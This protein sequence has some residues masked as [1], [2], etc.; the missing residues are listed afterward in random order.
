M[1]KRKLDA[2]KKPG[3]SPKKSKQGPDSV[4]IKQQIGDTEKKLTKNEI[5]S[6]KRPTTTTD[7][8]GKKFKSFQKVS[9]GKKKS[10]NL[11][12]KPADWNEFKKK[13]KEVRLKRKQSKNLF[14]IIIKA[15]QIG[16]T[17]RKKTL[18]KK[19]KKEV[20]LKR[21]QSKNLFE[22]IIKAKQIG[23]TLRKKTLSGGKA[24]RDR[25]VN[26]LHK[27][28]GGQGNY[29][30]FVLTHDMARIVQYMLKFG[31]QNI[32]EDIA[33]EIIPSTVLMLQSKYGRYCIKRL[34][35]YGNAKTRSEAIKA[36]YGNAVKL[37]S[38]VVSAQIFEYIY[39]TWTQPIEKVH[40]IQEFF[41]DLYKQSK[42]DN[43]KHLQDVYKNSPSMKAAALG[44][45]KANLSRVLN[46]DLL[47]S[48]LIQSVLYQYITECNENDR[49]DLI[50]QLASH[51]VILCNS[52]D[53][54]RTVM[55]CIWHGTNKDRKV[56]MKA[57]KEHVVD[58]CKH[59]FGHTVLIAIFDGIDDTVLVNKMIISEILK[60][61][62]DIS[63]DEWGRKVILWLVV[64]AHTTHFHPTFTNELE[65]G[66]QKSSSKKTP[67]ARRK[68]ILEYSTNILLTSVATET[69]TWFSSGSISVVA[70]A[71]LKTGNG[72]VLTE[73]LGKVA[74]LIVEN[75]WRIKE[76]EEE[77]LAIEHAGLH[78]TL[79]KLVQNDK[80]AIENN[81]PT[82]SKALVNLLQEDVIKTW[83][84]MNRGCFLLI[85]ILE[86]GSE[87]IVNKLKESLMNHL[88]LIKK[89]KTAGSKIILKKLV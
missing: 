59:E 31:N 68:E 67:E 48:R 74:R 30:K 61:T 24:E 2:P 76:E 64:P 87:D 21:K 12:E 47:D 70:L 38:H 10:N 53:G 56:I 49:N 54:S 36:M 25:L 69:R 89:E 46:K 28:L 55:E 1:T 80:Q 23:E 16:E 45:V 32:R 26:E 9:N 8:Q 82:F 13:K 51:A 73:A 19:K 50:S 14:E 77:I 4:N 88:K 71:I 18:S 85:A 84:K 75:D 43:V 34:F 83:I 60:H 72:E 86:N 37:T 22:I 81:K 65:C 11:M 35:K 78:M 41:G 3:L 58:L 17:L 7:M 15:K 40:L 6:N 33:K 62:L 5:L 52:K 57:L 66:R 39:S 44:A 29:V 63:K 42:E 79:K 27:L 20:R